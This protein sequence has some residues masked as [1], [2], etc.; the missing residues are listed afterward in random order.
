MKK[1]IIGK[2][3]WKKDK[4]IVS[5]NCYLC[6]EC[7]EVLSDIGSAGCSHDECWTY[8]YQCGKCK[9]VLSSELSLTTEDMTQYGWKKL[10]SNPNQ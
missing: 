5:L 7:G 6:P 9:L 2:V 10:E 3:K 4:T 8:F 1:P